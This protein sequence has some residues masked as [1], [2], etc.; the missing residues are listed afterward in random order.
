MSGNW[1][2]GSV[3]SCSILGSLATAPAYGGG[4]AVEFEFDGR[5][6]SL[7]NQLGFGSF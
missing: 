3:K 4:A 7:L 2:S 5:R 6:N 1:S